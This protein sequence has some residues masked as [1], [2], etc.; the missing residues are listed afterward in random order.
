MTRID[1]KTILK[2][3]QTY[4]HQ[5]VH[6]EGWVRTVRDSKQFGFLELND[7]TFFK[8]IQIVFE[9]H[10][11][12]FDDI[13]KLTVG[14]S[15]QVKGVLIESQGGKQAVEIQAKEVLIYDV[16]DADYPLQ[17]KRHSFEFLRTIPHLRSRSNTFSAVFR[18]RSVLSRAIHEFFQDQGFV[19]VHTP[20]ISAL[21]C[22][23]AG[24]MFQVTTLPLENV[25]K[26]E[27]HID[28]Q[29]D[30]F[31]KKTGLT[32]S[33][34]LNVET[35]AMAFQKVYTFGPTFRA[36][37]S[38]TSRHAAEFWMIEPEMAFA[39]L[40]DCMDMAESLL[41]FVVRYIQDHL[42]E[43]VEFFN[44]FIEPTL[45]E[46]LQ[47]LTSKP[48]ARMTYTQAVEMLQS[49]GE[50]F[51][52]PVSWGIDLQSEHEQYICKKTGVP[53]FVTDYPKDIK[54]FYMRRNKDQKTVAAMDLLVPGV[55]ELMGGSQREERLDVLSQAMQLHGLS[56]E[57]YGW[58]KDTRRFGSVVHSGFGLGFERLIQY[59]TGM[60]NIRDVIP[61][62]RTPK[63]CDM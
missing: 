21:D 5:E 11:S 30:F 6:L 8:G 28:F 7:G 4:L 12:N 63:N 20:I 47:V 38:N 45:K 42:P 23:G 25:P 29:K 9:S 16:A 53:T 19:W 62:P 24:E 50:S 13:C 15:V 3:H 37:N 34:Q 54:A 10:L 57:E 56:D 46:R 58:Y 22:E 36:E 39:D 55:G 14:S 33:G 44:Q 51:E 49:C 17:K 26:K 40:H 31:G 32:V 48:F 59:V 52:F 43:E 60:G 61:F 35:F 1:I 2:N 18:V 27:S 41:V